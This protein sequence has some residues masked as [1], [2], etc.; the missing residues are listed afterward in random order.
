MEAKFFEYKQVSQDEK[1]GD[2][3]EIKRTTSSPK[4]QLIC[5]K[6]WKCILSLVIIVFIT[7]IIRLIVFL[8]ENQ[9]IPV[10]LNSIV[11]ETEI[12]TVEVADNAENNAMVDSDVAVELT[13][14]LNIDKPDQDE[15]RTSVTLV[16]GTHV[17]I[18]QTLQEMLTQSRSELCANLSQV[19]LDL[20]TAEKINQYMDAK[21][22]L[23]TVLQQI[24][25]EGISC[26]LSGSLSHVFSFPI[27]MR[28]NQPCD[29]RWRYIIQAYNK[30]KI[31]PY[32]VFLYRPDIIQFEKLLGKYSI[33][34]RIVSILGKDPIQ[35]TFQTETCGLHVNLLKQYPVYK[36]TLLW[37]NLCDLQV[38]IQKIENSPWADHASLN[39]D[40]SLDR[41][42]ES[43]QIIG[44]WIGIPK[45]QVK[46]SFCSGSSSKIGNGAGKGNNIDLGVYFIPKQLKIFNKMQRS[47]TIMKTKF[48]G[49]KIVFVAGLEGVG[50]HAFSGIH[51][52]YFAEALVAP[53]DN[54]VRQTAFSSAESFLGARSNLLKTFR[55]LANKTTNGIY[56][57]RS[58]SYPFGGHNCIFRRI[59]RSLCNPNLVELVKVA[60][61]ANIDLRIFI[62]ERNFDASLVSDT[63]HRGFDDVF[64]QSKLMLLSNSIIQTQAQSIDSK[65]IARVRFEELVDSPSSFVK[66]VV[67]HLGVSTTSSLFSTYVQALQSH[68]KPQHSSNDVTDNSTN[69]EMFPKVL[70]DYVQEITEQFYQ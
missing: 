68:R 39:C 9:I 30:N 23:E 69:V 57:L 17:D 2:P 14:T 35:A 34:L 54:F 6:K 4:R 27:T 21:N 51:R 33:H 36:N 13:E 10:E 28:A 8:F 62:M 43:I 7:G 44:S 58:L 32:D 52:G 37:N 25:I 11:A 3:E 50:H 1:N 53:M 22:A 41:N 59:G 18:S 55:D 24:A 20:W 66:K 45:D 47:Q 65:F 48:E 61:E 63:L 19:V 5:C 38:Q 49:V 15:V 40:E 29:D 56:F 26:T 16:T 64:L 31:L 70:R 67:Y 12:D 46:S 42:A 60:E